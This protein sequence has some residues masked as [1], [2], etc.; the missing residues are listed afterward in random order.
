LLGL[1]LRI[2]DDPPSGTRRTCP[3]LRQICPVFQPVPTRKQR[4]QDDGAT[5][6]IDPEGGDPRRD[7][8]A[9]KKPE[10]DPSGQST[11][12]AAAAA[13]QADAIDERR[14]SANTT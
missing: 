10:Q 7:E 9:L 6:G 8:N 13:I 2:L 14:R 11:D 12:H 1:L 5:G 3:H 4:D